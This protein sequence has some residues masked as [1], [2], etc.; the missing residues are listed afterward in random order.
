MKIKRTEQ[1]FIIDIAN[2]VN[3][4]VNVNRLLAGGGYTSK[5]D[6]Q[7]H[8]FGLRN[9][10]NSVEK[11]DGMLRASSTDDVFSLSIMLPRREKAS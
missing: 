7:Y 3:Q 8:G 2:S 10:Q 11:N 1:F 4:K 9:I 5:K 6:K